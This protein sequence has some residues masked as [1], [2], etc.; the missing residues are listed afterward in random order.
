MRELL[1][2]KGI[3]AAI[4]ACLVV[5]VLGLPFQQI[6]PPLA[7]G[8]FLKFYEQAL[9]TQAVL[10][11]IPIVSVLPVGAVFVKESKGGF[12]KFYISRIDRIE[13]IRRKT[14]QVYLGGVLPLLTAGII[15]LAGC[16]LF[17]YPLELVGEIGAEELVSAALLLLRIC[18]AT[19][20]S[21]VP[22]SM[23]TV[24]PFSGMPFVCYYLLV[25]I[26]ERYL[27]GMYTL[28]PGEWAAYQEY[29]GPDGSGIWWMLGMCSAA[30]WG[31]HGALLYGK[32]KN[33]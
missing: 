33:V 13:Y 14:A 2:E 28:Y 31:V 30:L 21:V 6:E 24:S 22:P 11:C 23:K 10:F 15:F 16:F 18:L 12:L 17:L 19:S 8:T 7:A 25:I 26:K 9:G 5:F 27:P 32:L 20:K 1:W 29:W 4:F 3:W